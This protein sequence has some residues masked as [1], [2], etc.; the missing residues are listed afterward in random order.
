MDADPT[1]L[2]PTA[3]FEQQTFDYDFYRQWM[4]DLVAENRTSGPE[5]TVERIGYTRLNLARMDRQ[6]KTIQLLPEIENLEGRLRPMNWEVITEAWCGDAA[7]T[8]P[9]I[10]M[11]AKQLHIPLTLTL[12]DAHPEKIDRYLTNGAR[13][14]PKV[15]MR[16]SQTGQ[17][18]AVWGPR[19][20]PAQQIVLDA[21]AAGIP[22]DEWHVT[23]HKWYSVDKS[24]TL[25]TEMVQ[26]LKTLTV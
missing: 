4:K 15:I 17:D 10:Y 2:E 26:L 16:D 21:K 18:L 13:A 5:Q 3:Q 20:A 25:Q 19:P 24:F 7:Q 14:I 11:I 8:L 6:H 1:L 23:L 22:S 9:A 12:R